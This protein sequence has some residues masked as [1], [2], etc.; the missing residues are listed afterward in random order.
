M[1]V[2]VAF[3]CGLTGYLDLEI[4]LSFGEWFR[5]DFFGKHCEQEISLR[6]F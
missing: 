2:L 1:S 4:C 5:K 3:K 6:D